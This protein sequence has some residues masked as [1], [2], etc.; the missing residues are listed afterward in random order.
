MI[1]HMQEQLVIY[2][3]YK[4]ALHASDTNTGKCMIRKITAGK[5]IKMFSVVYLSEVIF[6]KKKI[7]DNGAEH[8]N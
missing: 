7:N 2:S 4:Y 8:R 5:K 1:A 3:G 6:C